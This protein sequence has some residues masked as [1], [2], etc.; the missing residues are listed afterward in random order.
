MNFKEISAYY[1]AEIRACKS[2]IEAMEIMISNIAKIE[3][4]KLTKHLTNYVNKKIKDT[5]VTIY[6][7]DSMYN[8]RYLNM[9]TQHRSVTYANRGYYA[10]AYSEISLYLGSKDDYDKDIDEGQ[11]RSVLLE[12]LKSAK[13]DLSILE[14]N[15]NYD[16]LRSIECNKQEIEDT[17]DRH[18][19]S[20]DIVSRRFMNIKR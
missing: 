10:S 11:L 19:D 6:I 4:Y 3:S 14:R 15:N 9:L 1:E 12:E 17:I 7:D 8:A 16:I 5:G 2:Q 13:R 20:L 18:N